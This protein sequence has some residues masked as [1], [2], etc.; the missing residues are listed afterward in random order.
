MIY[1]SHAIPHLR[2]RIVTAGSWWIC[3]W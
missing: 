1:V 2:L 3:T